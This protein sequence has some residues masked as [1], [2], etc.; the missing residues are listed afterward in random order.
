MLQN[1]IISCKFRDNNSLGSLLAIYIYFENYRK[2][3]LPIAIAVWV[4][5]VRPAT[6]KTWPPRLAQSR[7][8]PTTI[9]CTHFWSRNASCSH[10]TERTQS[11]R[12]TEISTS[13]RLLRTPFSWIWMIDFE[14]RKK[15]L[16]V[17][18]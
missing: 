18:D 6:T 11:V 15:A 12:N 2:A 1:R 9:A 8:P 16:N 4:K 14:Y 10:S 7:R 5:K 3:P 17:E 13:V